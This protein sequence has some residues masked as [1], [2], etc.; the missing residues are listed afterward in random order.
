MI[1]KIVLAGGC[2]WCTEAIFQRITGIT[3]VTSGYA[4]GNTAD[5]TYE[6][7]C[8]EL[9]G[10]AEA[11]EILFDKEKVS[12][13]KILF[14]FF[15][16]HDPTTLNQQGNDVGTRYRS[17]VFYTTSEQKD[18]IVTYIK[19]IQAQIEKPIVTQV[20]PL[21]NFY[22]AEAYHQNYYNVNKTKNS[23]CVF[24]IEPKIKRLEKLQLT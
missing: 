23:Y 8:S 21:Q 13:E 18:T 9:T 24:V 10:F 17:G 11:I 2:F 7:V 22:T 1:E 6:E 15:A 4:N 16:T 14:A 5:P 12:L 19:K 20:E 3:K